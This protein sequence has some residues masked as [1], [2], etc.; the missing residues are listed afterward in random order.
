MGLKISDDKE[1]LTYR[2]WSFHVIYAAASMYL[3]MTIT[4]W[5][6]PS[7]LE[8]ARGNSTTF[9]IKAGTTAVIVIIY[10]M[11]LIAPLCCPTSWFSHQL[12]GHAGVITHVTQV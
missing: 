11:A 1:K 8:V 6:T 9:W 7:D 2:Y 3:M 10:L 5:F 12:D 4:N